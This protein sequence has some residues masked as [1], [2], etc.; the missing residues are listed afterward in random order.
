MIY[1]LSGDIRTGKTTAISEWI[2]GR[3]NVGGFLS[4]DEGQLR[5]LKNIVNQDII[6]FEVERPTKLEVT[7]I[8]K[9]NFYTS[10]FDVAAEW[11][12]KHIQIDSKKIIII[13]EIG[14]LELKNKGFHS[15]F[16][17]LLKVSNQLTLIV[18]VRSSLLE[19]VIEKYNLQESEILNKESLLKI[20]VHQLKK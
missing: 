3:N 16:N 20:D 9:F 8:G 10:A 5:V 15:F 11:V 18:L 4:P 2:M 12:W 7:Q 6:P 14:K 17:E 13:D 1:L 19:E